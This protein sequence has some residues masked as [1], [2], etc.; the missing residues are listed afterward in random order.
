MPLT[1]VGASAGPPEPRLVVVRRF[2]DARLGLEVARA[3]I[4]VVLV[5][6]LP[7]HERRR[8]LD[9]LE[10]WALGAGGTLDRI[11]EHTIAVRSA[12]APALHLARGGLGAAAAGA[13]AEP[14]PGP[15]RP[16]EERQLL[17]RAAAVSP[18]ARRRLVDS[19]AEL[20][21]VLALWLRPEHL[22]PT[23]AGRWAQ[24][25]LDALVASGTDGPLLVSLVDAIA[26]RLRR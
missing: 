21:A 22:D 15:L 9:L 20:A 23:L 6:R 17:P 13:L 10:G 19:Y 24:Q 2:A 18:D 12:A 3:D 5:L 26:R 14:G 16:D 7:G 11:G 1:L 4:P 8:V 25:E